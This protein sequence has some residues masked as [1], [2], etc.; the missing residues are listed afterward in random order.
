MGD[1]RNPKTWQATLTPHRSLSRQGFVTVMVLIAAVNFAVGVLFF[2][3]GAWPVAGFAGLDVLLIWWA[4]RINFAD[5]RR[6]ERISITEHDV[7]FERYDRQGMV[8]SNNLVRRWTRVE[9][10]LDAERELV[11]ALHLV[12]GMTR[13]SVGGFLSGEER[14]SLATA[15]RSALAQPRI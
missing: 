9:L 11:G 12:S 15:L 10:D 8:Q 1:Q 13:I 3:I 6:V 5:G 7:V 4:F 14:Q 2:A